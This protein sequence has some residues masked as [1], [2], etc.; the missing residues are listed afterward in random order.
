MEEE[1]D[2][3]NQNLGFGITPGGPGAVELGKK[4]NIKEIMRNY[5]LNLISRSVNEADAEHNLAKFFQTPINECEPI[6]SSITNALFVT[7]ENLPWK[8]L[9]ILILW[10]S[11][12]GLAPNIPKLTSHLR[13]RACRMCC[14]LLDKIL[15]IAGDPK[16]VSAMPPSMKFL[17]RR[18]IVRLI[19][20]NLCNKNVREYDDIFDKTL[21]FFERI[22]IQYYTFFQHEIGALLSFVV[23]PQLMERFTPLH[24]RYKFLKC[25]ENVVCIK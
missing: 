3:D 8:P 22:M 24:R 2:F 7:D 18:T 13:E 19:A 23:L 11:R 12:W 6:V 25:I 16:Y 4:A 21:G 17:L 5:L 10:S 9:C 1:D 20:Y 14:D 15:T